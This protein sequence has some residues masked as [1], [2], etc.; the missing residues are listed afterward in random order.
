MHVRFI[1]F[2]IH[3]AAFFS[4]PAMAMIAESD[5]TMEVCIT[6]TTFP[7]GATLAKQVDMTLSTRSGTGNNYLFVDM[8]LE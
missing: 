1:S 2:Y 3:L 7:A 4:I 8:Q 5:V 6:M